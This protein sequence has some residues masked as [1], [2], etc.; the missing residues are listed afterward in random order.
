MLKKHAN[1]DVQRETEV[2]EGE[3][4]VQKSGRGYGFVRCL[5]SHWTVKGFSE[6]ID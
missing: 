2:G 6:E 4:G 1:E 5:S 3:S